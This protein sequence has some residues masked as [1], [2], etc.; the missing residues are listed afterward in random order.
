MGRAFAVHGR[1]LGTTHTL[2]SPG[3]LPVDISDAREVRALL[4]RER[5]SVVV[6]AAAEAH[7]ERCERE[8]ALTRRVNVEAA[9][10]IVELSH[11]IDATL[12]VF[13]SEYVFDGSAGPYEET[14]PVGPIN[15]YGRQK[16]ELERLTRTRP[17]HLICRTSG[18]YGWEPKGRNFVQRLVRELRAGRPFEV[19][20]DQEIT[21][22][23]APDLADAVVQL[24]KAGRMGTFHVVGPRVL[25]RLEF[26][27][28]AQR[29]FGLPEDLISSRPTSELGLRAPRPRSC[30]LRDGKLRA[31]LGSPLR[32]PGV[33]LAHMRASERLAR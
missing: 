6:L 26:A 30:G 5:P 8:P 17:D 31:A 3:M 19:P 18:V 24:L 11:Q 23:Y 22:T 33:A 13:S 12:I 14:D 15:E 9:Q 32:D 27:R 21:P 20:S 25:S 10:V 16:V 2:P 4:Y 1:V 28:L 29:T 7:V